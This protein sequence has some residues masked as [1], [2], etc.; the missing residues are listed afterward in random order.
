MF[1]VSISLPSTCA[2]S[3]QYS[4]LAA[5]IH[6]EEKIA[7]YAFQMFLFDFFVFLNDKGLLDGLHTEVSRYAGTSGNG[8]NTR[9][10]RKT[11]TFE[12]P[13]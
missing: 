8:N 7:Q 11:Y 6:L 1:S 10:N 9:Q 2:K 4:S 5:A 3:K 12:S 13:T